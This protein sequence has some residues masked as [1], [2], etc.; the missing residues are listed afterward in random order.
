EEILYRHDEARPS[1]PLLQGGSRETERAGARRRGQCPR[2]DGLSS[3][4]HRPCGTAIRE[5][6]DRSV[7]AKL[8]ASRVARRRIGEHPF[9]S[10]SGLNGLEKE[11]EFSTFLEFGPGDNAHFH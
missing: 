11:D 8:R 4:L 2:P 10:G 6:A 9:S 3:V 1:A 5:R 7:A